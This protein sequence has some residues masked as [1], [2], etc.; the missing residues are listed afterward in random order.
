MH[1]EG[2]LRDFIPTLEK[3]TCPKKWEIH[4]NSSGHSC[5]K[6]RK[7][8]TNY[9]LNQFSSHCFLNCIYKATC[10]TK[11]NYGFGL[12]CNVS[13]VDNIF[14]PRILFNFNSGRDNRLL[15]QNRFPSEVVPILRH[16]V[17]CGLSLKRSNQVFFFL[18]SRS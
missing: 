16:L 14:F 13:S 2:F 3:R 12:C 10:D 6:S 15:E 11:F 17:P 1:L 4:A 9:I 7:E 18:F 8:V 5:K